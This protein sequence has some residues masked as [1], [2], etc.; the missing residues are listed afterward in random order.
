MAPLQA[1]Y[2][3]NSSGAPG[4]AGAVADTSLLSPPARAWGSLGFSCPLPHALRLAE[5]L[6]FTGMADLGVLQSAARG[7]H[8]DGLEQR[9]ELV[10]PFV[11][12]AHQTCSLFFFF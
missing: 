2:S 8:L 11:S 1:G 4:G 9:E 5:H 10:V 7:P 3:D 6:P 12:F